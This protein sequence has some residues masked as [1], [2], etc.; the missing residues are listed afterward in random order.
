MTLYYTIKSLNLKSTDTFSFNKK[1]TIYIN[2]HYT[3][4]ISIVKALKDVKNKIVIRIRD[5]YR[6]SKNSYISI[7]IIKNLCT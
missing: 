1:K 5:K 4:S 7:T 2:V 3:I 6:K